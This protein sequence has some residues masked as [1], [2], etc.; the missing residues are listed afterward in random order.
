ME[1]GI[2][3]STE[4]LLAEASRLRGGTD[5]RLREGEIYEGGSNVVYVVEFDDGVKWAARMLRNPFG[6]QLTRRAISVLQYMKGQSTILKVP[7]IYGYSL[8]SAQNPI[9]CA[10]VF[11]EWLEGTPL[12]VWNTAI[13]REKRQRLLDELADFLLTLWSLEIPS[14]NLIGGSCFCVDT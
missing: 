9:G 1:E 10:Y 11:L 13:S 14:N 6:W 3:I 7:T 2:E 5:C 4:P 12:K 8:E